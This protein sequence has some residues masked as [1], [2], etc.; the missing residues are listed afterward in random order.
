MS[1][2]RFHVCVRELTLSAGDIEDAPAP[3]NLQSFKVEVEGSD[4][5]VTADAEAI[6]KNERPTK[7]KSASSSEKGVVIVGGGSG[8]LYA[9]EGLREVNQN[10]SN[11]SCR[12]LMARPP[13]VR[14]HRSGQ[15]HLARDVHS[16]RPNQAV[17]GAH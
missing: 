17:Q 16:H 4:I 1:L 11:E 2:Q 6:K 8:A 9:V 5:Y 10:H 15:G 14:L 12:M 13:A 7:I 3:N